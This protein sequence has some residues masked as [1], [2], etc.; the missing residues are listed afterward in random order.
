[1]WEI[2]ISLSSNGGFIQSEVLEFWNKFISTALIK[3]Y[4]H[5]LCWPDL[6]NKQ[7]ISQW[8]IFHN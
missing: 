6:L 3:Q 7:L 2:L 1:M 4:F 8:P 5:I